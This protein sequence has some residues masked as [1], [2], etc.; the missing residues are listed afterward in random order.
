MG[1]LASMAG[2]KAKNGNLK[3]LKLKGDRKSS[4]N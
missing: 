4:G 3:V 2:L 1:S